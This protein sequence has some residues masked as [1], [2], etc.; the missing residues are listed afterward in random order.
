MADD[1]LG[2]WLISVMR[3]AALDS[4]DAEVYVM[5]TC[6]HYS[7][8]YRTVPQLDGRTLAPLLA[9]SMIIEAPRPLAD[10]EQDVSL[11]AVVDKGTDLLRLRFCLLKSGMVID[12]S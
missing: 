9:R 6:S 4:D 10:P 7:T 8:P 1:E 12:P 2:K 3:L 5:T 11:T